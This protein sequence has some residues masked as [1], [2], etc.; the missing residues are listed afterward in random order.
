MLASGVHQVHR[1]LHVD[2]SIDQRMLDAVSHG[3]HCREVGDCRRFVRFHQRAHRR[4]IADVSLDKCEIRLGHE[5]GQMAFFMKQRIVLIKIV[6]ADDA[7]AAREQSL[8]QP[9]TDKSSCAG[10]KIGFTH[11]AVSLGRAGE[12]SRWVGEEGPRD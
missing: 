6:Q 4:G 11:Y 8:G 9:A 3:R 2:R 5:V 7:L 12:G 1:A 10:D